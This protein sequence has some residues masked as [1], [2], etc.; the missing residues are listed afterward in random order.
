MSFTHTCERESSDRRLY[1]P[2]CSPGWLQG[3][4]RQCSLAERWAVSSGLSPP[5]APPPP[6]S[7][8]EL[9]MSWAQI[10][11]DFTDQILT[12][13]EK[14]HVVTLTFNTSCSIFPLV[15]FNLT[16]TTREHTNDSN[17][18]VT[19]LTKRLYSFIAA[20]HSRN[21]FA[22]MGLSWDLQRGCPGAPGHRG[23]EQAAAGG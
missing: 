9:R 18:S 21:E 12:W 7:P 11:E 8:W 2:G 19:S 16:M 4:R 23:R 22:R 17:D 6:K 1:V 15:T 20:S 5:P 10:T 3:N 13:E 14:P